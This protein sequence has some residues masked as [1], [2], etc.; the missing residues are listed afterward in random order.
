V[1]QH[2]GELGPTLGYR[3]KLLRPEELPVS[4]APPGLPAG[5]QTLSLNVTGR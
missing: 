3:I 5:G 4:G 2:F 1:A